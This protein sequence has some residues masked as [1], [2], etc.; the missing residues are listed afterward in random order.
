MKNYNEMAESVFEKIEK[1][2]AAKRK[3]HKILLSTLLPAFSLLVVGAVLLGINHT[4]V[5]EKKE[6]ID[7]DDVIY[8]IATVDDDDAVDGDFS[9]FAVDGDYSSITEKGNTLKDG[10]LSSNALTSATSEETKGGREETTETYEAIEKDEVWIYYVENGEILKRQSTLE[11]TPEAVFTVWRKAH[12]ITNEVE[13]I[14]VEVKDNSKTER[15][16]ENGM[17]IVK[18][19]VGDYFIFNLTIS[20]NIENYY[21]KYDKELLLESLKQTMLGYSNMEYDEYHLILE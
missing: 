5:F 19:T 21:G 1:Y 8:D 15:Y 2:N 18:H 3:K 16:E 7:N 9:S 4:D 6:I 13:L 10:N 14:K 17:G 20:K 11:L 12:L